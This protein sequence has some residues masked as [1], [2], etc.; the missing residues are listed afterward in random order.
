[1]NVVASMD[2]QELEARARQSLGASDEAIYG[3]VAGIL[4]DRCARGELLVD[5]GCGTGNLWPFVRDRFDR[6]IGV[7]A[8]RHD[9]FPEGAELILADL[10]KEDL[11]LPA[12]CADAVVAVET[13]EHLENPRAFMRSILRIAKP[14]GWVLVT[15]PNQLSLLSLITLVFKHRFSAFQDASYPAHITALIEVDLKRIASECK[16]GDIEIDYSRKGRII[17]SPWHF[18]RFVSN[19][20][21]RALSDNL[22]LIGRKASGNP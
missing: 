12:G 19:I 1:M 16:L 21:P 9:D 2:R 8:I 10:D 20:F 13:I 22:I 3:R 11:S 4:K 15:T 14:G 18:P 5:V 7:D 6:Y 17:L